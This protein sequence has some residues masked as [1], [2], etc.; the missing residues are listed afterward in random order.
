M[1]THTSQPTHRSRSISHQDCTP[2]T[3][4]FICR[5]SMQSTGQTSRH[6]SQPVQLSALITASSLGSFLRG[7]CLAI[8]QPFGFPSPCLSETQAGVLE[9]APIPIRSVSEEELQ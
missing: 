7:P 5:S 4:R 8:S 3:P 9:I 2:L 6:D 1:C